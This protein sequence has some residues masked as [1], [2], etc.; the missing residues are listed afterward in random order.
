MDLRPS[1]V[2]LEATARPIAAAGTTAEAETNAQAA[3]A[4]ARKNKSKTYVKKQDQKE[5]EKVVSWRNKEPLRTRKKAQHVTCE[6]HWPT[7]N[8][9]L[10]FVAIVTAT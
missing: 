9:M 3:R 7:E 8:A 4:D 6:Q 5:K 1:G 10:L 2:S